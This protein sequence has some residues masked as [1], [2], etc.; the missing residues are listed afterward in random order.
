MIECLLQV[1]LLYHFIVNLSDCYLG[2]LNLTQ[3]EVCC[4]LVKCGFIAYVPA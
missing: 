3:I 1:D 2:E 4:L